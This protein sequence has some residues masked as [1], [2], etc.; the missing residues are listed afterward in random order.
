MSGPPEPGTL[1]W[2]FRPQWAGG[3]ALTR[4]LWVFAAVL[5]LGPRAWGIGD[6]YGAEDM[7]FTS[8]FPL[9]LASRFPLDARGAW[10]LWALGLTGIGCVAWGGRLFHVGILVWAV[11]NWGLLGQEALNCKAYDRLLTWVALAL[12][13]SPAW[14]R[15]LTAKWRSPLARLVLVNIYCAAYG[16]TGILKL[17]YEPTW[18]TGE[19]LAYHLLHPWFGGKLLGVYL[20][21][22]LWLTAF[23]GWWTVIFEAVFPF[24]VWFKRLNPFLLALGFSFHVG[25]LFLM[26]VGP[27]LFVAVSAYPVL[28]H[29]ELGRTAWERFA[30]WRVR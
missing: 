16:S 9:D 29:P 21:D 15:G 20:S 18:W 12:L 3:W 6:V 28:L 14:E 25:L 13:M 11:G 2:V 30:A 27:F 23:M 10:G 19:V 17:I 26:D 5:C 4:W 22:Q 1:A 7:V 8:F 24:L